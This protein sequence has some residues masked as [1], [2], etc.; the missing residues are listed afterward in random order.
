MKA[1]FPAWSAATKG[2]AELEAQVRQQ[3]LKGLVEN[4]INSLEKIERGLSRCRTHASPFLPSIGEFVG[5][6]SE[7]DL[8][9]FPEAEEA[10]RIMNLELAK[11]LV[12]RDWGA[13]HPAIWWVYSQKTSHDWKSISD[14]KQAKAFGFLWNEARKLAEKNFV[15]Q[16][17]IPRKRQIET[18]RELPAAPETAEKHFNS[19]MR[20]LEGPKKANS[21]KMYAPWSS[22]QLRQLKNKQYGS[23]PISHCNA[24][25]RVTELGL[26]CAKCDFSQNWFY[27]G[28]L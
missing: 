7:V 22:D 16:V 1:I 11:P 15:F 17:P 12:N 26:R 9:G 19:L 23:S 10:R 28:E 5:W 20:S 27:P 14:E 4:N 21:E 24:P 25:L 13:L 3:W 8:R 2:D 18:E 6:C